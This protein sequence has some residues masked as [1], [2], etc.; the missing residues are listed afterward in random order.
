MSERSLALSNRQRGFSLVEVS[1]V[2]TIIVILSVLAIPSFSQYL[3]NRNLQNAAEDIDGDIVELKHRVLAE[4]MKYL[5]KEVG[6]S[7]INLR[8]HC[9]FFQNT[10]PYQMT[11]C[12][13]DPLEIVYVEHNKRQWSMITHCSFSLC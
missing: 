9:H 6:D 11:I 12:V 3:A 8:K 4:D 5:T 13:V 10:V 7:Q 1:I 2:L